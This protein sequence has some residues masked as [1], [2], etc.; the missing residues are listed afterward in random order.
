LIQRHG[1]DALHVADGVR[2][3]TLFELASLE[4]ANVRRHQVPEAQTVEKRSQVESAVA[5]V[6]LIRS[7]AHLITRCVV[8]PGL[9]VAATVSWPGSE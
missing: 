6:A 1:E 9:E 8:E 5:L 7:L 3:E 4:R 2:V